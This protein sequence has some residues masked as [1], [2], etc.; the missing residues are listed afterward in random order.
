MYGDE[1]DPTYR[2]STFTLYS[3]IVTYSGGAIGTEQVIGLQGSADEFPVP[4]GA[5]LA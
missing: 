1:N 5:A 4:N 2:P 3:R